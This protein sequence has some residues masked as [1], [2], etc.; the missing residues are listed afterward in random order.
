MLMDEVAVLKFSDLGLSPS[1]VYE[2][3]GYGSAEPDGQVVELTEQMLAEIAGFTEP[4]FTYRIFDGK[5]DTRTVSLDCGTT[6]NTSSVISFLLQGAERFAVFAA[7]A[8][9]AFN[10]CQ[11]KI[12]AGDDILKAFLINMIG[13]CVVEAAGDCMESAL[14]NELQGVCHTARYSPGYCGWHITGQRELFS[15]L[16]DSPC[17]IRLTDV[18][19]ML[20][21]KSISGIIGIG[22]SVTEKRYGCRFCELTNCYKRNHKKK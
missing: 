22:D 5:V 20:P 11:Q 6:L 7:T 9:E 13:T 8:G 18:C 2:E 16:G 15:L 12:E 10:N 14:E 19:L 3:M 17:G 1:R 4:L 21:I